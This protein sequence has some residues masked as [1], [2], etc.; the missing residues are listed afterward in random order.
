MAE[1]RKKRQ[2]MRYY[3]QS[4]L[5]YDAQ[6]YEEQE[7]KIRVALEGL[8]LKK[9][10]LLLDAGCGTGLLLPHFV[11]K[12]QFVVGIDVSRI[13]LKEAKKRVKEQANAALVRADADN[14]PFQNSIFDTVFAITLLQNAPKPRLTLNEIKR[15][16]RPAATIVATTLK[17][18]FSQEKFTKLLSEAG[19]EIKVMTTNEHI[20]EYIAVCTKTQRRNLKRT[21][22]AL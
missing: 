18:T 20:N 21:Q 19:L 6:Y 4:A 2:T 1:W 3:D 12:V 14:E 17:K 10:S 15:V 11:E 9:E 22:T 5:V 13:I 7:A 16:T 8:V